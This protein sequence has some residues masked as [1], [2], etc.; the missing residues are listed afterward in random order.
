MLRNTSGEAVAIGGWYLSD[1]P[2]L[3]RLWKFPQ[4]TMVPG[5][6]T[7]VVYCSGLNRLEDVN[8]LHTS[9]RLSSEGETV[10]LSN[11]SGQ[12]VDSA[13]YDLLHTDEAYTRG[14]DGSWSVGT[15]AE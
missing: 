9:F 14:P 10:T 1:T 3:P 11:A 6:G 8:H 5:G 4:G 12:P 7:L 15:P 2:R 13:T